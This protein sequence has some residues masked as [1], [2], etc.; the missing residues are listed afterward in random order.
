MRRWPQPKNEL[1]K[2]SLKIGL[3]AE[4]VATQQQEEINKYL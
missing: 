3:G 1:E 4:K 2:E